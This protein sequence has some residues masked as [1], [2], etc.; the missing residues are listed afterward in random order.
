MNT[1]SVTSV[2]GDGTGCESSAKDIS[3]PS[4]N[5]KRSNGFFPVLH[6]PRLSRM[7]RVEKLTHLLSVGLF[8]VPSEPNK[9]E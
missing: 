7:L 4:R 6:F 5:T 8:S 2:V 1:A 9:K 3:D